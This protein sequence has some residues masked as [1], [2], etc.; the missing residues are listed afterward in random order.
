MKRTNIYLLIVL[1]NIA[2]FLNSSSAQSFY[3]INTIQTIE[4][5]FSQSNWDYMLD[6]AKAGSDGYIM[7]QSVTVN[8]TLFDSVGVKYKGNSTY[9]PSYVKNPF[10]IELDTYKEQDYQGYKDIKMSNVAKDPS[11]LREVLSYSILRHYMVAPLSNYANVY[12]N[13]ALLG[14]YVSSESIGK[15]FVNK[16]FYSKSNSFFKC[17]PLDGAGPGSTDLPNLVYLGT[18]S[19]LYYPAYELKSDYGWAD[20]ITLTNTLKNNVGEIE[21]VLDV[22]RALW[23]L[24]F[25]NLLVNLDSYIGVFAQNYYLY[26]D[27]TGRFN[28][29]VWDLNESFGTFSQTGTINLPNTTAKSQM[30][31]LLHSGDA[32]WPLVQKLLSIPTYKK[33]YLAHLHTILTENISNNSYYTLAQSIQPIINAAVQAD[34]NKFYTY[35]QYQSN[36]TT[37]VGIGPNSAPGITALMNGRNT[38]LSALPDFTNTKP[39]ITNVAP[40]DTNP[41]LNTSIFITANVTNTNTDAVYLGYRDNNENKFTKILMYDDGAHGDG[42]SG[43]NVYGASIVASSSSIQYYI[44]AEN[45]NIGMFSPVRAEHEFYSITVNSTTSSDVVM[46]EIYSRGTTADPD[47]IELYNSSAS[48]IDISGY[49]IYDSGGQ[50]GTKPKKEFP[51][52]TIIP[53]NEFLVIVTDDTSASGF[54]LSSSGEKVWF[55]NTTGLIADSVTFPALTVAQSYGRIPDGGNWQT[56]DTITRGISNGTTT[57]SEIVLNEIYSRGTTADPD[58]I[59]I[60]NS[61]TSAIDISGYKIYDSGGQSGTKPKKEFPTGSVISP[62]GFLVIVTDDTSASG[63]GLSSSGE[64]VW[65][66]NITGS[67]ADSVTF[68]ALTVAQSYGRIP[69]GGVWQIMDTITRGFSNGIPTGIKDESLSITDYKLNQNYPNPFNPSTT[70]SFSIPAQGDVSLKIYDVLGKEVVTLVDEMKSAGSYQITFDAT[71]LASG[72]YFYRLDTKNFSEVKKM[73]L[74]K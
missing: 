58:W 61:S 11:F 73:I 46:N 38:Y 4:I 15:T 49:K 71:Q 65:L 29:I 17:N 33:M 5:T 24:A 41:T 9:N 8:G 27:N 72:M 40:S 44:Y 30:T 19:T 6:T 36:L 64:T 63:F 31:H 26:E 56:L 74:L 62:N 52:G 32:N 25:D 42:T 53:S 47:W 66:E 1:I 16:Y 70:I 51:T 34:P 37:D 21:T 14:L 22:D 69:D 12:V 3:D 54:G 35:S 55:E 59:E 10:H 48:A 23:M 68:S 28:S 50:S 60:Y 45:N 13:G 43:D 2:G 39:T 7:A 67:I 20:L 18:D 57:G